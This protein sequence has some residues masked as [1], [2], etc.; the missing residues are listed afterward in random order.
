MF[1]TAKT[2]IVCHIDDLTTEQYRKVFC[3]LL[4]EVVIDGTA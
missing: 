1:L 4:F 3:R 2:I